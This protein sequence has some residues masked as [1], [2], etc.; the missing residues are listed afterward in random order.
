[1]S[2]GNLDPTLS[3]ISCFLL[4][5]A[6]AVA[7]QATRRVGAAEGITADVTAGFK[8]V[9]GGRKSRDAQSELSIAYMAYDSVTASFLH[10]IVILFTGCCIFARL[11]DILTPLRLQSSPPTLTNI[12][13]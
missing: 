12:H 2:V 4:L 13:H 6:R 8:Y 10:R 11:L 3:D 5:P 9:P 7:I 1:M